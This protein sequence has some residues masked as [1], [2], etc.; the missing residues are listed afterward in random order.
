M[1]TE[2][3]SDEELAALT[4]YKAKGYQRRWLEER[5]WVFVET[6]SGRPLVG[7]HYVRMKLGLTLEVVPMKPP[8]AAPTWT[9]DISKVR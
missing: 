7:R 8:P 4:G 1:E 6:R 2:I 5:G 3:L 9:P